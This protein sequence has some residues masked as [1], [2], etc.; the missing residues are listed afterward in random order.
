[1]LEFTGGEDAALKRLN[2]Y[3]TSGCLEDYKQTRNELGGANSSTKFSPW[4]SQGSLSVKAVY[5]AVIS[6]KV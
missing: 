3:I 5:D 1:M 2:H 6:Y 4:L